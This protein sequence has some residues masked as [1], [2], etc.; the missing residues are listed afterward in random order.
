[1]GFSVPVPN[2][3]LRFTASVGSFAKAGE[4]PLDGAAWNRITD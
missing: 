2:S 3:N 1:M 4:S